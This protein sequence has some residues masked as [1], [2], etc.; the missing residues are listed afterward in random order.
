MRNL[1]PLL[2]GAAVIAPLYLS[3][4]ASAQS[5]DYIQELEERV[6]EEKSRGNWARA[7]D[8]NIQLNMARLQYQK[9][10]GLP[11]YGDSRS[12]YQY[13]PNQRRYYPNYRGQYN[14]QRGYYDRWG[15][16]RSY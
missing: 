4:P 11:E 15:N 9:R 3:N 16:W 10:H 12:Y 13:Q 2:L 6:Q 8:L 14:G 1:I 5:Y 7:R